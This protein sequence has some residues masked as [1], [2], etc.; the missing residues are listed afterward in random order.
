MHDALTDV[1]GI[2]V[3]QWTDLD[4][5]TGCTVVLCPP[6]GAVAAYAQLGG[7]PGTRETDLLSPG[8][9]VQRAHALLLT[10]GSAYG[11]DAAGGVMRWLE[12]AGRGYETKTARV[13][14]VPAAVIYDLGVGRADVRPDGAAGYAACAAAGRAVERGT[15]GAGTGATVAKL[16][17]LERAVKGGT[18]TASESLGSG[19]TVGALA[20]VNTVGEIVDPETGTIVAGI[21]ALEGEERLSALEH[22][23][24]RHEK[25]T[26]VIENTTVA[27]VATDIALDRT[28]LLRVALMAHSGMARTMRPS[29]SPADGDTVFAL[30]TALIQQEQPDIMAIGALAARALERAI[31]DGVCRATAL[32]G[33]PAC[34][35]I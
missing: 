11:L 10:G 21:R 31:L 33:F 15:A 23:R 34:S 14:I 35:S 18:G 25:R 6:E 28:G 9:V 30:S 17:G 3:G 29:H 20:I 1:P 4:A 32:A 26:P 12:E 22:L 13:P 19:G 24:R 8:N 27:V 7:A 16:A 2:L 5:A